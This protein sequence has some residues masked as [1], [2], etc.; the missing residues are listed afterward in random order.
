[1][2]LPARQKNRDVVTG[3]GL[4]CNSCILI[5]KQCR[6]LLKKAGYAIVNQVSFMCCVSKMGGERGVK[7]FEAVCEMAVGIPSAK[8][9]QSNRKR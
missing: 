8:G 1:V 7:N 4:S 5:R 9:Y 2:H 3:K 6:Y